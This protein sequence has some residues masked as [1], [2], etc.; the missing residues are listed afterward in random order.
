MSYGTNKWSHRNFVME[1]G[2]LYQI[3]LR[4]ISNNSNRITHHSSTLIVTSSSGLP[5]RY[6]KAYR[7]IRICKQGQVFYSLMPLLFQTVN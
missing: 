2:D 7:Y 5:S 6:K 1:F 4:Y 3:K